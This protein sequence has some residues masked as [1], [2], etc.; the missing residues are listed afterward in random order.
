MHIEHSA[1][2]MVKVEKYIVGYNVL[3]HTTLKDKAYYRFLLGRHACTV[4]RMTMTATEESKI[5]SVRFSLCFTNTGG[6]YAT[7]G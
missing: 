2:E 6:E 7:G 5:T 3:S 4:N 1:R